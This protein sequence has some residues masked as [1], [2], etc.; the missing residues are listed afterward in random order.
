MT[1][2]AIDGLLVSDPDA[3]GRGLGRYVDALLTSLVDVGDLEVTALMA[4]PRALP[5]T[6]RR[7]DVHRIR[8]PQRL[9]WYE[10]IA[11]IGRDAR[12]A[13]PDVFHSPGLEPPLRYRRPW[14]QTLHDV[15][16]LVYPSELWGPELARWR[17]RGRLMRHATR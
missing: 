12:R 3:A 5:P 1:S 6:V 10:H 13:Q 15:I 16:P 8:R 7:V 17:L 4:G 11:R 9:A 2:V 14:V